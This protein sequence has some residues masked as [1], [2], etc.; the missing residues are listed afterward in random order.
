MGQRGDATWLQVGSEGTGFGPNFAPAEMF[1][2]TPSR[3]PFSETGS[4]DWSL[5]T[6]HLEA[7]C[8]GAAI[9]F[10]PLEAIHSFIAELFLRLEN[11]VAIVLLFHYT[12]CQNELPKIL[13]DSGFCLANVN[14]DFYMDAVFHLQYVGTWV[15]SPCFWNAPRCFASFKDLTWPWPA[16]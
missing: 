3:R 15:P 16:L 4:H 14:Y 7:L 6:G 11:S 8:W 12:G 2:G 10:L 13:G 5:T 1:Q 9:C